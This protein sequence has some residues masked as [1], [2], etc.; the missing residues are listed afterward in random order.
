MLR[1]GNNRIIF[2]I[3]LSLVLAGCAIKYEP[4]P[5]KPP[6]IMY[7]FDTVGHREGARPFIQGG[8]C[9]C[10]PTDE[11]LR[12]YQEH[13]YYPEAFGLNNL[14]NEYKQRGIVT[15][16]DY[17]LTNNLD[18]A[19]PHVVFGGRSMIPP[20]PGT[21]NYENVLFGKQPHWKIKKKVIRRLDYVK[22]GKADQ[23]K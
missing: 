23:Q 10:T 8:T 2:G 19:G 14:I 11:I 20:T 13:G 16:L 6:E 12:D 15:A 1:N 7:C 17:T 9:C 4:K 18:D 21:Q 22:K 5:L 3:I